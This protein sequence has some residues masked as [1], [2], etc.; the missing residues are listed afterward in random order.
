MQKIRPLSK[1]LI[2]QKNLWFSLFSCFSHHQYWHPLKFSS[3]PIFLRHFSWS[4][5]P[6]WKKQTISCSAGNPAKRNSWSP[7][8]I[9]E[10]VSSVDFSLS[11]AVQSLYSRIYRIYITKIKSK[12]RKDIASVCF[13]PW[14]QGRWTEGKRG[15]CTDRIGSRAVRRFS[16]R[17]EANKEDFQDSK[18]PILCCSFLNICLHY[19]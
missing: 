6:T 17:T 15:G 19:E 14:C 12:W 7:I 1:D 4:R 11:S 5:K 2:D 13:P 18:Y 8:N 3:K 16:R 9:N 10:L